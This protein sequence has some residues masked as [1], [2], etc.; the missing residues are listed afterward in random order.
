MDNKLLSEVVD[1]LYFL[2]VEFGKAI[3]NCPT[4]DELLTVIEG[5]QGDL[6]SLIDHI[7]YQKCSLAIHGDK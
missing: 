1:E 6:D 4:H 3:W 2:N 5:L 7:E